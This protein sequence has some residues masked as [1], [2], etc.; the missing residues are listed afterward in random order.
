MPSPTRSTLPSSTC[1]SSPTD[2]PRANLASQRLRDMAARA[3]QPERARLAA[4]TS[5]GQEPRAVCCE[6]AKAPFARHLSELETCAIRPPQ[7]SAFTSSQRPL[8]ARGKAHFSRISNFTKTWT[9]C[10]R[11]NARDGSRPSWGNAG[12]AAKSAPLLGL[13]R[14]GRS[15]IAQHTLDRQPRTERLDLKQSDAQRAGLR[16]CVNGPTVF[17]PLC[18]LLP[19]ASWQNAGRAARSAKRA[20]GGMRTS[21]ELPCR[22]QQQF[23]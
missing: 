2:Q 14:F 18:V 12:L 11:A 13:A 5:G 9:S 19:A 8:A 3:S 10:A 4:R 20:A 6:A 23:T 21:A 22:Q 7:V 15:L 17:T 16:A 1:R